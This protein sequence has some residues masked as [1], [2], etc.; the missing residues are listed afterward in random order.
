MSLRPNLQG[1]LPST[2]DVDRAYDIE[3]Q[4]I[5]G[6]VVRSMENLIAQLEGSEDLPMHKLLSLDK[7]LRSI[8]GSLKVEMA[9]KVELQ[10]HIKQERN[11][12]EEIRDNPEYDEVFEKTSGSELPS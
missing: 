9:K 2:T 1:E 10:Q 5:T 6:N 12:L 11:K 8:R 3:L 7:Q 4:E